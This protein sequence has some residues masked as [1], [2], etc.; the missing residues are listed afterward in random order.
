M[1]EDLAGQTA[2]V[3]GGSRGIGAEVCRE[4][5]RQGVAVAVTGRD[6][7]AIDDVVSDV[8][9][10]GASAIGIAADVTVAAEVERLREEAE[11]VF[12]P[13]DIVCAFAGGQGAPIAVTQ[14]PLEQW[15]STLALNLT[16][17]FLTLKT[18]LPSMTERRH[19]AIVTMSST[20]GRLPSPASPAYAVAKA[21]LL[22][23]TRQTALQVADRGVRLN[24]IALGSVLE[25]KPVTRE[26]QEQIAMVHPLQRTG[27]STD[28]AALTAFLVSSASAWMTGATIDLSGGRVML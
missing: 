14:L 9:A 20:A 15:E 22:M 26:M 18:F 13:I 1:Y 12:G 16:S 24:A 25:G 8:V 5:G 21:G 27:S 2:L 10:T 17:A 19:G 11:A 6:R 28:V 23:L 7:T 3:T 4:L